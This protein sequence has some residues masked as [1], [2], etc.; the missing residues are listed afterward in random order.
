MPWRHFIAYYRKLNTNNGGKSSS[1]LPLY[2][3]DDWSLSVIIVY[4]HDQHRPLSFIGH[5]RT[6]ASQNVKYVFLRNRLMSLYK[7]H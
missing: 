4:Q 3:L 6:V 2:L 5:Y 7:L 1:Y